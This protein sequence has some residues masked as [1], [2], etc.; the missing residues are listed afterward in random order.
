MPNWD[1][2]LEDLHSYGGTNPRPNDFDQFW[3]DA[4][5]ELDEQPEEVVLTPVDL[6]YSSADCFDLWFTGIGGA[7]IHAKY[8]R[9]VTPHAEG[10]A[11]AIFHGY[12]VGSADWIKLL[13]Y[14]AEGFSV[15]A[16]DC[17]GQG[18][19]SEDVS[20]PRRATQHGHIVRGLTEGP[21]ALLYRSVFT[22]VVRTVRILATLPD[23]DPSRLG[24][25][26]ASQ[27]G[28]LA[29][30][31]AAL[32]P[33]VRAVA[34]I[35]PFLCD[36]QRVWDLDLAENAYGE[37]SEWLRLFDPTHERIAD[38]FRTLGYI[39]VQHLAPRIRSSVLMA[40]ALMDKTCPPSTQF[41]AYNKSPRRS[42]S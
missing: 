3:S 33:G 28:G 22:D 25:A 8:V 7:R 35:Y 10:R 26:G 32:E 5:G 2:T 23:V 21:E 13:P 20:P 18:G 17:R 6:G 36:Y 40:T 16:L 19:L 27:G 29:L 34:A 31:A 9:P 1:L 37:L 12:T 24:A 41:A 11:V 39:D 14:A 42:R 4:F 30:V 38:T 15:I